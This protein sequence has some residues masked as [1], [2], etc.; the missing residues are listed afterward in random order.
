MSNKLYI[1]DGSG[2]IFRAFYAVPHL[3][4]KDGFP[5]NALFGFTR[6]L[7]K[8]IK[9]GGDS[10]MVVAFDAGRATFRNELYPEY[11]AN[12]SACPDELQL[13]MPYFREIVRALGLPVL[14]LP[15]YEADDVIGTLVKKFSES[16]TELVIVTADKDL[17]QLVTDSIKIWD[18]MRDRWV[19][20]AEVKEKF[21]VTPDKV[22]DVLA[23]MGDSSDNVPGLTGAG[24]K[25]A[26]QL[27]EKYGDVEGVLASVEAIRSDAA[28]RSRAKIA[29]QI[30]LDRDLVRL[31]KQL[32]QINTE[33]PVVIDGHGDESE[34]VEVASLSPS[35]LLTRLSATGP[36]SEKLSALAERFEFSSLFEG[37]D[38]PRKSVGPAAGESYR[39]ILDE[40]FDGWVS[41]LA[42]Q[43]AF[44]FDTETSS[45]DPHT[46]SLIG[47]SFCWS[48]SESYYIPLGHTALGNAKQIS[49]ERFRSALAPILANKRTLKIGQN[50]KFD[51]SVLAAQ[52]IAVAGPFFDTMIAAYLLA[53]DRGSYN[54]TVLAD[55]YLGRGIV[56]YEDVC[57]ASAHLGEVP[58]ADVT[59]YAC[60]DAHYCWLLREKLDQLLSEQGLQRVFS[61]VEMPLVPVLSQ[62]EL[63][64]VRLN[65]ELLS[66]MSKQLAVRLLQLQT[67]IH[68]QCGTEFNINSPKQLGEVL[69]NKLG[70]STKGIKRT[71][72]GFSTDSSVLEKLQAAHPVAGL[73]LQYR[74]LHK[75]QSTY[76]DALP[77]AVNSKT[78]RLHSRFNQTQTGTGRLSSSEPNLQN[79]PIQTEEGRKIRAAFIADPGYVLI[80]ADYSQIELRLLAHLSGDRNMIAAFRDG[81]DVHARTAREIFRLEPGAEVTAQQRRAGKTINFGIVYGMGGFRLS[82]ELQIPVPLANE[83][84][85]QYFARYPGVREYFERVERQAVENGYVETLFGRKRYLADLDTSGRDKGFILRAAINA[86]IQGTAADIIKCA[87]VRIA[88]RVSEERLPLRMVLQIHDELLFEAEEQQ[89]GDLRKFVVSEM[90]SVIS[91]D[92]PLRVDAGA[93]PTWQEAHG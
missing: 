55:E 81:E 73:L 51:I 30:E 16:D 8:L 67:E 5:T 80:S 19:G 69:F 75:L 26:A 84:I 47:A 25:T 56:E 62:M 88:R 24:P 34:R 22:V 87:M 33:A 18:T 79:I 11:K 86:P 38:K 2:Y 20:P 44:S 48:G 92:V 82:H 49:L 59:R 43:P 61:E 6:M 68:N 77:A 29:S 13:Q 50:V 78:G 74:M 64:G 70:L 54:L 85:E 15:G 72:N 28:I 12:R 27:I 76:I 57:G 41:K 21:G 23:L 90:E 83:Y 10:H 31:S 7:T 35:A 71:K 60:Q 42:Q 65:V 3:T 66:D 93:G 32:V 40:E 4:T 14:E 45:L 91:L 39:S 89:L 17:M 58:V 53:P 52:G 36:N 63:L 37:I 46:S 9:D 1:V